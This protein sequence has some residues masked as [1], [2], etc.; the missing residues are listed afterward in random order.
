MMKKRLQN[1]LA[2]T[3]QDDLALLRRQGRHLRTIQHWKSEIKEFRNVTSFVQV[4]DFQ[5]LG[6]Y[7]D[8]G[9]TKGRGM[10]SNKD[11]RYIVSFLCKVFVFHKT[12]LIPLTKNLL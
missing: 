7:P 8:S 5:K 1:P 6:I 3:R 12:C 10:Y 4:K 11:K 2:F 9:K